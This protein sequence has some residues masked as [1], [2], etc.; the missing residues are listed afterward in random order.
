MLISYQYSDHDF[1]SGFLIFF[2]ALIYFYCRFYKYKH[3][4]N[5]DHKNKKKLTWKLNMLHECKLLY[6]KGIICII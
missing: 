6:A 5:L 2:W 4:L 1:Y 3:I